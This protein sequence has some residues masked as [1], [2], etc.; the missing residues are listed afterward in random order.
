[1]VSVA[2]QDRGSQIFGEVPLREPLDGRLGADGH[3]D[4]RGD[5]AMRGMQDPGTG[6]GLGTFGEKFENDLA[7]QNRL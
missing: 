2:E 6:P 1:V 3:E 7:R 5:I 4:R